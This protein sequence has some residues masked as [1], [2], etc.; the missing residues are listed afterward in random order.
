MEYDYGVN[1]FNGFPSIFYIIRV[2]RGIKKDL[3]FG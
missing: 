2:S 1:T 3:D